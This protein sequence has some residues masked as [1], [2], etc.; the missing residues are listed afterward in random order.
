MQAGNV[1]EEKFATCES[2]RNSYTPA[3]LVKENK[4]GKRIDYVMYHPGPNVRVDLKSYA[5]PLPDRVP[6][7]SYRY[8]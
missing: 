4:L 8:V 3:S 7:K 5:L 2:L 6:K 1:P